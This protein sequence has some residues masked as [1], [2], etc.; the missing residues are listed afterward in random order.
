MSVSKKYDVAGLGNALMDALVRLDDEGFLR[1]H[2][3]NKGLMHPVDHAQWTRVYEDLA[4]HGVELHSGGSCANTVATL[5]LMGARAIYCGQVG[6]DELGHTYA[7][8][9]EEA[10]GEHALHFS[11]TRN[12][13]KC[14]S[15]ISHDAERTMLTDLGAAIELPHV[16]AF[17]DAVR[18]SRIVHLTGYLFLGG[19]MV[20]AAW[21]CLHVAREARVPVSLDVADPFVV[22]AQREVLWSV[23]RDFA[24]VVFL[25]AEEARALTGMD[26]ED[27]VVEVGRYAPTVIVKRGSQ[28]SLVC[29]QGRVVAVGIHQADPIDTTGAGD[30]FAAGYLYGWTRGW[31]PESCGDLGSW[32]ASHV[33]GQIG[34]V[35]RDRNTLRSIIT[36]VQEK[37]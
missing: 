26:P 21:E 17:A 5:G 32:V 29:H 4:G 27:A 9:L 25:N 30:G 19:P 13:G 18:Q 37:A 15:I 1:R 16:G 20:D 10:C 31:A 28:G 34:A 12:T 11:G 36:V 22:N 33:V 23:I 7:R 6:D 14:L 35:F 24:E 2:G 8:L 3:L